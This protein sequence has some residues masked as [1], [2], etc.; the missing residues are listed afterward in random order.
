M[1][2]TVTNLLVHHVADGHA[3]FHADPLDVVEVEVV[4]DGQGHGGQGDASGAT[5]GLAG[6]VCVARVVAL[7]VLDDLPEEQRL[8]DLHDLLASRR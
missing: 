1:T 6:C 3:D 7:K 4:K 5:V 8:N 2:Q